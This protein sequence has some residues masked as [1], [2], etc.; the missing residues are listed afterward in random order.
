MIS[1]GGGGG[2]S[3]ISVDAAA[4]DT[5]AGQIMNVSGGTAAARGSLASAGSAAAGC[6]DPASGSFEHLQALV[7]G[8]LRCLDDCSAALGRATSAASAAYLLTDGTQIR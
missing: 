2:G 4:L 5:M 3:L 7:A 6:Q 1:G 8:V